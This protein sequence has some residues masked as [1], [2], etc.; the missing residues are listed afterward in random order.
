MLFLGITGGV[1]AGKSEILAYLRENYKGKVML[2][3]TIAHD[4]MEPGTL[5]YNRLRDLFAGE[6]I[7]APDGALTARKWPV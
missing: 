3:D 5:C 2:A 1:G 6:K 7:W 4:L